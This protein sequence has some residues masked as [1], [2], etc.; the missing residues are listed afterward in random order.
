MLKRFLA[1]LILAVCPQLSFGQI[2]YTGD[3]VGEGR[4]MMVSIKSDYYYEDND[5]NLIIDR[6]DLEE[7]TILFYYKNDVGVLTITHKIYPPATMLFVG[8]NLT[9][10]VYPDVV[11]PDEVTGELVF[12][13]NE[14]T[15]NRQATVKYKV[16]KSKERYIEL[17]FDEGIKK[18]YIL[19]G[20]YE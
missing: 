17:I 16:T 11:S 14:I 12:T 10:N 20:D 3:E 5:G 7:A 19:G 8:Y 4:H 18:Y 9:Y 2:V 15:L 6:T 13:G 1:F